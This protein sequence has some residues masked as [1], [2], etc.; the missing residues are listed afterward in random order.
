MTVSQLETSWEKYCEEGL[1]ILHS[2]VPVNRAFAVVFDIDNTLLDAAKNAV[3]SVQNLYNAAVDLGYAVFIVTSR[4]GSERNK[5]VTYMELARAGYTGYHSIYWRKPK[6]SVDNYQYKRECRRNIVEKGYII[7]T[8]VGDS[9]W[10]GG[11]FG[12]KMLWNREFNR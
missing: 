10:D 2:A 12:G 9:E 4:E 3:C 6:H 5:D 8:T 11:T 7:V 1:A